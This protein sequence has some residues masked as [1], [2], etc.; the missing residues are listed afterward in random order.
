M[1]VH[2]ARNSRKK[3]ASRHV[4]AAALSDTSIIDEA[5]ELMRRRLVLKLRTGVVELTATL[6][7]YAILS[8]TLSNLELT[9]SPVPKTPHLTG[10]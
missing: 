8:C 6:G 7:Y 1:F 5:M 2:V 9:S 10:R 3:L 4:R